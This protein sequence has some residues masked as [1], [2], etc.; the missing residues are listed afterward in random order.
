MEITISTGVVFGVICAIL[1]NSRGRN[2]FAWFLIGFIL[3]CFGLILLLVLPDEADATERHSQMARENRR[4]REQLK[5]DRQVAE[6]RHV[7]TQ[8][9]LSSHDQ[10]LNLDTA[11]MDDELGYDDPPR[12]PSAQRESYERSL[13]FYLVGTE[14]VG[15]VAF[16]ELARVWR[17]GVLTP[18]TYVW[19][20]GMNDW[21]RVHDLPD[22][23][24]EFR[25]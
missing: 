15:P 25:A 8:Q 12:L 13:W 20:E 19:C 6:R 3:N 14:Q 5:R 23:E 16:A 11:H 1:A 2:A 9:R 21:L 24:Q 22:L 7:A 17:E 18:S 4:L 10:A